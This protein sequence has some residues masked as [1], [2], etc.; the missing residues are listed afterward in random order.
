MTSEFGELA[1]TQQDHVRPRTAR[2]GAVMLTVDTLLPGARA[3]VYRA[4]VPDAR[5]TT[6]AANHSQNVP[7]CR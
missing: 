7:A 3:H 5:P 4:S 2:A 6:P 1:L